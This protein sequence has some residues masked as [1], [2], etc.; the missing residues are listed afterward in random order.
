MIAFP[1]SS[2]LHST[3]FDGERLLRVTFQA[4][5][6]SLLYVSLSYTS[7]LRTNLRRFSHVKLTGSH[8]TLF[9][10]FLRG[11]WQFDTLL[12]Y[13][14]LLILFILW[15]LLCLTYVGTSRLRARYTVVLVGVQVIGQCR[16]CLESLLTHEAAMRS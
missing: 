15:A 12:N 14:L 6:V 2:L 3:K 16:L 8:V 11:Y 10:V 7:R 5:H 4:D 1:F 9:T 13:I